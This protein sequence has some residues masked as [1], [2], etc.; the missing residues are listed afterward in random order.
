MGHILVDETLP[1]GTNLVTQKPFNGRRNIT[2]CDGSGLI[3]LTIWDGYPVGDN[4]PTDNLAAGR[5]K[6]YI[7]ENVIIGSYQGVYILRTSN[8]IAPKITEIDGMLYK[9]IIMYIS[10]KNVG[11][12]N[13]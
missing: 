6:V 11:C 4:V 1:A 5:G 13:R 8:H 12:V 9:I 10:I 3:T 7:V 2:I